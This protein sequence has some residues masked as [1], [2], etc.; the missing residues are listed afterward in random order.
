[1]L[2]RRIGGAELRAERLRGGPADRLRQGGHDRDVHP[3]VRV[4]GLAGADASPGGGGDPRQ[5]MIPSGVIS[6]RRARGTALVEF[7]LVVPLLLT[8]LIGTI[9][10][11]WAVYADHFVATAAAAGARYAMVRGATCS[12]LPS[13][14]PAAASDIQSYVS[15]LAPPG[16]TA[17]SLSSTTSWSPN[18]SPGST[19][20]V[21]VTYAFPM[22]I[23]FVTLGSLNLSA[24]SAVV[25]AQ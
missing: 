19:V 4:S 2:R 12:G 1:H 3:G 15:S 8:L 22:Q 25:I 9:E 7:A 20:T 17:A 10:C 11:G 6:R 5:A 14:C 16:V 23:P 21:V 13:A 18:N 24:R